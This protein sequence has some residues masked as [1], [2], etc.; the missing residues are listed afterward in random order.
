[1]LVLLVGGGAAVLVTAGTQAAVSA[2][3]S[4]PTT[5]PTTTDGAGPDDVQWP[6][7]QR[8]PMTKEYADLVAAFG[9]KELSHASDQ[10]SPGFGQRVGWT[11][12]RAEL[13]RVRS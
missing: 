5:A 12:P 13:H 1:M 11:S 10:E 3:T 2:D 7:R 6:D 9:E 4:T 8:C